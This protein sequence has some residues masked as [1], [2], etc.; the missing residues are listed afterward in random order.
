LQDN[1]DENVRAV[2]EQI[3]RSK[4]MIWLEIFCYSIIYL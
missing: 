1:I 4:W 3:R 2:L